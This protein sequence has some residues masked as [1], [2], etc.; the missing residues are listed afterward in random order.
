MGQ[1]LHR[2]PGSLDESSSFLYSSLWRDGRQTEHFLD[3]KPGKP[4]DWECCGGLEGDGILVSGPI[5]C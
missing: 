2:E 1:Q 3:H 4:L 5:L